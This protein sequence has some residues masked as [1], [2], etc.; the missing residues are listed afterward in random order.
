VTLITEQGYKPPEA[1]FG[2]WYESERKLLGG[3]PVE[4]F[5]SSLKREWPVIGCMRRGKLPWP[6]SGSMWQRIT[7]QTFTFDTELLD[8]DGLRKNS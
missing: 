3:S 6:M 1:A 5:F 2:L 7:T 4:R 8:T